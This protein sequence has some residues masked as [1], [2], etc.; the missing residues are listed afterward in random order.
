MTNAA[1][2]ADCTDISVLLQIRDHQLLVIV[3][4]NGCGFDVQEVFGEEASQSKLGLYGMQE[5][6]ELIGGDLDI[7]T[8]PGEGT[9]IYL[10]MPLPQPETHKTE[11][12]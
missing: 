8:Q 4:D 9:S 1:K 5:R 2:Y 10:R 12:T 7:E 3:E 6:A 11:V